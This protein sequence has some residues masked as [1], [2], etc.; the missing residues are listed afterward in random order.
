MPA[1]GASSW[2]VGTPG[3]RGARDPAR[4]RRAR[5]APRRSASSRCSSSIAVAV[6]VLRTVVAVP[7]GRARDR[8]AATCCGRSCGP[9]RSCSS[10]RSCCPSR[11]RM[12]PRRWQQ[13]TV[14]ALV[15]VLA[16]WPIDLG[17][18]QP[19]PGARAADRQ[20]RARSPSRCARRCGSPSS[21]APSSRRRCSELTFRA[22]GRLVVRA[23]A[24]PRARG[25]A[26]ASRCPR[27]APRVQHRVGAG[28]PA[29][30]ARRLPRGPGGEAAELV[31]E[32]ARRR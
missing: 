21:R 13:F 11:S 24:V 12:P 1:L 5:G 20:P 4:P 22:H 19:R 32:G 2:W 28:G 31:Q 29:A 9:R 14:A 25:A 17:D 30:A 10:A 8:R 18:D 15:G 26:P 23:R 27:H 3:A 7:G 6:A 16:G